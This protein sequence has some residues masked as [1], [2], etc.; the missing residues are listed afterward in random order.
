MSTYN[1]KNIWTIKFTRCQQ[2][3]HFSFTC[4]ISD[5]GNHYKYPS[6]NI[7]NASFYYFHVG[8]YGYILI[9][10]LLVLVTHL[11]FSVDTRIFYEFNCILMI[12]YVKE[13]IKHK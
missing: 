11:Q 13:L 7:T 3:F 4:C 10:C 5:T 1:P 12:S 6:F 8:T 2:F 9:E